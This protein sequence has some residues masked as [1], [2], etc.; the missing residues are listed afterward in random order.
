MLP[1]SSLPSTDMTSADNDDDSKSTRGFLLV[2]IAADTDKFVVRLFTILWHAS[3]PVSIQ[4]DILVCD[5]S[6][7]ISSTGIKQGVDL[8]RKNCPLEQKTT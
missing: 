7:T 1:V 2:L 5:S 8:L 4:T 6:M 3:V